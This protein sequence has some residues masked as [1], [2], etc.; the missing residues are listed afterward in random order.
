MK[1]RGQ[2]WQPTTLAQLLPKAFMAEIGEEMCQAEVA[3]HANHLPEYLVSRKV[4]SVHLYRKMLAINV[5]TAPAAEEAPEEDYWGE[6]WT[7]PKRIHRKSDF[8]LYESRTSYW[9]WDEASQEYDLPCPRRYLPWKESAHE[10]LRAMS[11][12]EFFRLVQYHGGRYPYLTWHDPTGGG[13]ERLAD[14][15]PSSKRE[16]PGGGKP[17]PQRAMGAGAVPPLGDTGGVLDG[18]GQQRRP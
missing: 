15:L 16:S 8:E 9:F 12:F 5:P 4:R 14:R 3:H 7:W 17:R 6:D 10:Q 18:H 13:P 1:M 2:F 11:L